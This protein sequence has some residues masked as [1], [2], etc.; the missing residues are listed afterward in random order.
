MI[1]ALNSLPWSL[2]IV[3]CLTLGLAPF[4]PPHIIEKLGMLRQ[5]TLKRP[6]DWFDLFF[7]ASPFFVLI[8]KGIATL[9]STA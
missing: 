9:L 5:G 1:D 8:A 7:H 3:A 4:R 2:V 6:L